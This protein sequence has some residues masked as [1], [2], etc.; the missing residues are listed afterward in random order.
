MRKLI[1]QNRQIETE[2]LSMSRIK[3]ML[4]T[5]EQDLFAAV[6]LIEQLCTAGRR[7]LE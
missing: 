4:N 7:I 5:S 3:I 1:Y 2:F 6:G